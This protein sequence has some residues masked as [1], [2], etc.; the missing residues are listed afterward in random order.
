M[1]CPHFRNHL[2][3]EKPSGIWQKP[4]EHFSYHKIFGTKNIEFEMAH[5]QE[6]I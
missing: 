3:L 1:A 4:T 2:E 5:N 6:G